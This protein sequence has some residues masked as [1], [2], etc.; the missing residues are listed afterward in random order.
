MAFK[1]DKNK[2]GGISKRY[3]I[4]LSTSSQAM[5]REGDSPDIEF[6]ELEPALVVDVN[7]DE[8]DSSKFGH[9]TIRP[10]HS[11]SG[12]PENL[13]PTAIP[14]DSNIKNYPVKNEYV[15]CAIYGG[16][17]YYTQRLNFSNNINNNTVRNKIKSESRKSQPQSNYQEVGLGNPNVTIDDVDKQT[18]GRYFEPTRDIKSLISLEGD[19]IYEGRFGNSIRFGGTVDDSVQLSNTFSNSWARGET[20]GSPIVILRNGQRPDV[21]LNSKKGTI[22]DI[23]KDSS[24]IYLTH[25]QR[26]P[27]T[28]GSKNQ[29]SYEGEFPSIFDGKQIILNSDRIVLNARS[30]E[31][32][33]LSNTSIGLSTNGGINLDAT[34]SITMNSP[35]IKFGLNAEQ[36]VARGDDLVGVLED[37]ISA[38][39]KMTHP[40]PSGV[41]G[42][43]SNTLEFESIGRRLKGILSDISFTE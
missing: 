35:K 2:S 34:N 27:L 38:I 17:Y 33:L 43:P 15:I 13:L 18:P 29:D 3:D 31:V 41:S 26:I 39:T 20:T 14:L 16:T 6:Y 28:K 7:T 32:F 5:G 36:P 19:I 22:E 23:N 40:T 12:T 37:L 8:S 25:D 30:K 9:V 24:S 1:V 4:S 11:H 42:P 10:I 21:D